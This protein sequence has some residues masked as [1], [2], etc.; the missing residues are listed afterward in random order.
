MKKIRLYE[1]IIKAAIKRIKNAGKY[2]YDGLKA[3]YKSEPAFRQDVL[4]VIV[5][6]FV[7]SLLDIAKSEKCFLILSL[8]LII[9]AE[10]INTAIEVL[11]D[12]ISKEKHPLSKKAKDIGSFLVLISFVLTVVIWILIIL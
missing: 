2:S 8:F 1:K 5:G 3:M 9:I 10:T 4:L 7:L 6:L 11:V 12:R